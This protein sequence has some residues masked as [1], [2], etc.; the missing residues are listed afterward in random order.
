MRFYFGMCA[1]GWRM[2][3]IG[4]KDEWF[5]GFSMKIKDGEHQAGG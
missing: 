1:W 5:L 3:G 4:Y 2:Y